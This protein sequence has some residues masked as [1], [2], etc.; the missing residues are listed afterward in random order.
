[1]I[2][3]NI[4]FSNLDTDRYYNIGNEYLWD[5]HTVEDLTAKMLVEVAIYKY[6]ILKLL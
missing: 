5:Y 6:K 3:T 2:Y 1:M 4:K